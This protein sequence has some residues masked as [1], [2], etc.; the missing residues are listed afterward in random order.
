MAGI[1]MRDYGQINPNIYEVSESTDLSESTQVGLNEKIVKIPDSVLQNTRKVYD[2]INK[3]L[4]KLRKDTEGGWEKALKDPILKDIFKL[5]DLKGNDV[6]VSVVIYND[7]ADRSEAL[8]DASTDTL[9]VNIKTPPNYNKLKDTIEHELVHAVDPKVRDSRV[10]YGDENGKGGLEKKSSEPGEDDTSYT[11]YVKSPWEFDA[12][13]APLINKISSN[14]RKMGDR[15][16]KYR[17]LL[18]NLFSDIRTKDYQEL[19]A[20]DKYVPLAW[21]FTKEDIDEENWSDVWD[22]YLIELDKISRWATKPTLYKQ[23]L[24]RLGTEI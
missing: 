13:T 24:K 2:Y 12:F 21:L 8:M 15:Q 9:Y 23:F 1:I 22:E 14:L 7:P 3:N 18:I 16:K 4:E 11:K 5:K 17:Q 19:A 6:S 10:Y 20:S